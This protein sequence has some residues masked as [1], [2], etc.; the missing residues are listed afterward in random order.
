MEN[1]FGKKNIKIFVHKGD[2]IQ[3]ICKKFGLNFNINNVRRKNT[4]LSSAS[5]ELLK[6]TNKYP[7]NIQEKEKSVLLLQ[8]LDNI[9]SLYSEKTKYDKEVINKIFELSS[10][11]INILKTEYNIYL[12]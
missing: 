6:L 7:L 2:I 4:S 10:I 5:I 12:D 8:K 9:L 3:V 1:L 11:G